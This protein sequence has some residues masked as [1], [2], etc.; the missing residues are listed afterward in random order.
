ML[1]LAGLPRTVAAIAPGRLLVAVLACAGCLGFAYGINAVAE[2]R[3]D[4]SAVKNPLVAAP[5]LAASASAAALIAALVAASAGLYLGGP[6]PAAVGLSLVCGLLYSVGLRGKRIPGLGLALNVGIFVPLAVLLLDRA[7]P[8]PS[9][10]HELAVFALLLAQNQL[11]HEH[12]DL[13]EDRRAGVRTTARLLGE[14]G[15]QVAVGG[16]G[17]LLALAALRL[18]PGPGQ[19]RVALLLAAGASW[20]GVVG[21]ARDPAAARRNH[22]VLALVGGALLWLVAWA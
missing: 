11:I 20:I 2:R 19:L 9:F 8:P 5:Q 21:L 16:L 10:G 22:R 7:A 14:R 4:R 13:D 15:T 1:P 12:A 3:S 18:A 6:A 17:L